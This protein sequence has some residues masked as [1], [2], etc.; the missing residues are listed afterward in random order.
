VSRHSTTAATSASLIIVS[1][2]I[3]L[4]TQEAISVSTKPGHNEN[5]R[6]PS[7]PNSTL[8]DLARL[9]S[10]ALERPSIGRESVRRTVRGSKQA[11]ACRS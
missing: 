4:C 11:R 7:L 9:D 8:I 3:R 10:A 2:G 1:C 5:A 6:T